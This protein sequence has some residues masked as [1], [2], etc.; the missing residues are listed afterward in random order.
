MTRVAERKSQ[1]QSKVHRSGDLNK[2]QPQY[3][4]RQTRMCGRRAFIN[5][6]K[7]VKIATE[8]EAFLQYCFEL[9]LLMEDFLSDCSVL[10]APTD[11][12]LNE[13]P[14]DQVA[15]VC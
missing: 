1:R 7:T 6:G 9:V 10:L 3:L 2:F 4:L 5:Y 8:A 12:S 14:V 15:A 11:E 13:E